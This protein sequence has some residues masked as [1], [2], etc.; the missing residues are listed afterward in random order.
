MQIGVSHPI[1]AVSLV[2]SSGASLNLAF[3]LNAT[4]SCII[5]YFFF[6][7]HKSEDRPTYAWEC[8]SF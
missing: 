7:G 4:R 1:H 6:I 2:L 8:L 3:L 5:L